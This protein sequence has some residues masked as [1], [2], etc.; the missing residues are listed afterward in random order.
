MAPF[1]AAAFL[2][3]TAPR[4]DPCVRAYRAIAAVAER[5]D[6]YGYARE[7]LVEGRPTFVRTCRR[8][9]TPSQIRCI[10]RSQTSQQLYACTP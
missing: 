2:F 1:L 3:S 9:L 6:N 5:E 4:Q 10:I 7:V 8:F